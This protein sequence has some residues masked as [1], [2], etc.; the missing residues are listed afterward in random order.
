M[1]IDQHIARLSASAGAASLALALAAGAMSTLT[2]CRGGREEKPPRQFFPDLDDQMKWKPQSE[3]TFFSDGRTM[4]RPV[5]NTVAF[6]RTAFAYD[7]PGQPENAWSQHWT[8]ARADLAKADTLFYTGESAPG[9]YVD[10]IP[11]AVSRQMLEAGQKKYQIYCAVCHG[12]TGDGKGM[13]GRQWSYTLPNFHDAKYRPGA[14]EDVTDAAGKTLTQIARTGLD[15]YLF[16][17][18]RNGV[19]DATSANKMPGYGHAISEREAWA[20]VAYIRALQE[21]HA[22]NINDA[23]IPADQRD[24]LLKNKPA[25]GSTPSTTGGTP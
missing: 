12:Y 18:A 25:A 23:D 2:G 3:S 16:H 24:T 10:R 22:V 20:V 4:R 8:D 19:V 13:V 7:A 11:V 5:K 17:V 15:G 1:K 9:V 21:A 6:G 14:T